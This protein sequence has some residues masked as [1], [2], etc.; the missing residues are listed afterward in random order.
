M[1]K[2]ALDQIWSGMQNNA[3]SW[4]NT[5][6][7]TSDN[8]STPSLMGSL[9]QLQ[10]MMF[11][12]QQARASAPKVLGIQGGI[13]PT[14]TM[15]PMA[16]VNAT[17]EE[18]MQAIRQGTPQNPNLPVATMAAQIVNTG[19]K[20]ALFRHYPFL[21][22][23]SSILESEGLKR[24]STDP[25][26]VYKPKQ[27]L[28]WGATLPDNLYNPNNVEQVF[29]DYMTA[30]GG[31]NFAEEIQNNP[32]EAASRMKTSD[33]YQ[34]FRTTGNLL[35][36]AETYAPTKGNNG[37]GGAIYAGRLQWLMDNYMKILQDIQSKKKR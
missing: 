28:G 4:G 17:P 30:I 5:L 31:R 9:G 36:F 32:D 29:N 27:A 12:P 16:P 8:P 6:G 33:T 20:Y 13:S 35:P 3:K 18:L 10:K 1:A 23:A 19:Q 22:V 21:P 11:P 26:L 2:S 15:N 24:F 37:N 7:I 25:Q 14:P 34:D